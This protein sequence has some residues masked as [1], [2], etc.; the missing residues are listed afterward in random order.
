MNIFGLLL[1]NLLINVIFILCNI[2]RKNKFLKRQLCSNELKHLKYKND[3]MI[4][5]GIL[6]YKYKYKYRFFYIIIKKNYSNK[7]KRKNKIKQIGVMENINNINDNNKWRCLSSSNHISSNMMGNTFYENVYINYLKDY[8]IDEKEKAMEKNIVKDEEQ[9]KDKIYFPN[10]NNMLNAKDIENV[11]HERIRKEEENLFEFLKSVNERYNLNC[12]LR[13]VGGWV[14]DKFLNINNDD[15]DITVDNMKGAEFCNYIKEYIKEK[16]NKNFNFGIIKINSDQSKHLE[17]SSFNL[18]N[19]QVDIVNLRNEKYTEE[20]RIP[21]IVIGT[22]EEDALRRDFTVNSLF[23]NLKNKK[24]EDYTEKGIF[25]LKNH[26]IST[27]LEPLAT[28]LDDP[29]RI[30]R[31]IRFCGFFNF[32]LEKSIFNVLKNEDIKKAFTK[33]ISKSRL[34]SEIV[35]IFSAKCKNVILS[36]TLLNYSS[37]SS[38]IFQLPS[39][40]FVKDEELFEKLKKKDKINKGIVTPAQHYHTNDSVHD[41]HVDNLNDLNCVSSNNNINNKKIH[42]QNVENSNIC[43]NSSNIISSNDLIQNKVNNVS[44]QSDINKEDE[45]NQCN[46][47]MNVQNNDKQN[48]EQKWLFDGLSYLKFFKEIEKNNLLKETF[49]NLDYKE[50]MN[51]I[52]LCLFLLPLKNHFLYI[53]NGKTE[54]V[55]EYIIRESLKFPLK[56]SKFCVHI[57][58]GFTHL[59]NL[60]K[61]IDVLN[62]LKNKNYQEEHNI[63]IKGQTVLCLKKIGDKWNFVFLIFYIFHKFNELNKNYITSITTNN[64]CLSDFVAKLYQYIFKFNLQESHNMKPFLK[65]PDIKHNFPNIS[66]NQI[67][68]VYEQIVRMK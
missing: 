4:R 15:I 55:V 62:F 17:T 63:Q 24:V 26:I 65:W 34:S 13:V 36:L 48:F 41:Q 68:E 21:E 8:I 9:K 29:L 3:N 56:Y 23:Y 52:Q 32:F 44:E 47:V 20:S 57:F 39:N 53:K 18:F 64:I 10:S 51:Y 30:V 66:P 6:N 42:L 22:P 59:Y 38:K 61:T 1:L 46:N 14:R 27:P 58:E 60:Y 50:N 35:K 43:N 19:F 11:I 16:E 5:K 31:C 49:N 54:Y 28:F 67:N 37:Y 7:I 45:N 2:K 33:K 40:Y 25:H 12:T